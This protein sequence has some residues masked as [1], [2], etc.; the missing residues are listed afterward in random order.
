MSSKKD[1]SD[2]HCVPLVLRIAVEGREAVFGPE[3][4]TGSNTGDE[5]N[6]GSEL[7][8]SNTGTEEEQ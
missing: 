7:D 3:S 5:S 8:T 2:R 4:N 6:T 1:R